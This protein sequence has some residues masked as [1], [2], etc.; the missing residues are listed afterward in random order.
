MLQQTIKTDMV[1]AMKAKDALR[2]ETLRGLMAAFTNELVATKKK[3]DEAVPDEMV[4]TVIRREV[5]KRKEAA[6]AFRSGNRAEL[7]DKED[8]ERA[9]LEAYLPAMMSRDD[10]KKIVEAK[11]TELGV[12]DKKEAGKLMG[13][14]MKEL[15]G[16]ADGTDVKAV[17]DS[18][19]I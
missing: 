16:K 10:I 2:V 8:K 14:V 3:P 17:I 13:M 18:L 7:A 11:K 19:F 1:S 5:K 15:Q 9:M 4:L 6:E 12:S